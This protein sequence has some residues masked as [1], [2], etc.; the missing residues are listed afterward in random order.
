MCRRGNPFLVTK[1]NYNETNIGKWK[2][3][4][5]EYIPFSLSYR[6]ATLKEDQEMINGKGEEIESSK[7][8]YDNDAMTHM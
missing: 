8:C 5:T 3:R 6:G 1:M 2:F 4:I 7:N